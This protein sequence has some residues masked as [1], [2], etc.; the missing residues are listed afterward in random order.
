MKLINVNKRPTIKT[1][2]TNQEKAQNLIKNDT[3]TYPSLFTTVGFEHE[4]G[5]MQNSPLAGVSHLIFAKSDK[6][7]PLTKIP[8]KLETDASNAIE[9][10]SPP[11]IL[12]MHD[13]KAIPIYS[14]V[15]NVDTMIRKLLLG[16]ISTRKGSVNFEKLL[17]NLSSKTGWKFS[18][19]DD[20]EIKSEH[21]SME[22]DLKKLSGFLQA[23]KLKN[24]ELKKFPVDAIEKFKGRDVPDNILS[25]INFAADIDVVNKFISR[26]GYIGPEPRLFYTV[27]EKLKEHLGI[28]DNKR[29]DIFGRLLL[30]RLTS[31]IAV[32]AQ[33]KLSEMQKE[34][35]YPLLDGPEDEIKIDAKDQDE[36]RKLANMIS[37][38]KRIR[39]SWIKDHFTSLAAGMSQ[40]DKTKKKNIKRLETFLEKFEKEEWKKEEVTEKDYEYF[41]KYRRNQLT[42]EQKRLKL[43]PEQWEVTLTE[44]EKE[45]IESK[46][47]E[48]LKELKQKQKRKKPLYENMVSEEYF[49]EFKKIV[50]DSVE[51]LMQ[52]LSG[53]VASTADK[54]ATIGGY[55]HDFELIGSRQDTFIGPGEAN[56]LAR[57]QRLH[58][59]E[60][61][62]GELKQAWK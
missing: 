26:T 41:K 2:L 40:T 35:L 20:L 21:L 3:T 44:E 5:G 34:L 33:Q 48:E 36:F 60:T 43:T 52:E 13:D 42:L 4:F 30:D 46:L 17:A 16:V 31:L 50:V 55:G 18:F 29:D 39:V 9:F 15:Q 58:V 38:V 24:N 19:L 14:M 22:A 56:I 51:K 25:Q 11:F 27:D 23:G 61:D 32:P 28:D 53:S 37:F 57:N 1:Y 54:K 8:F 45:Q 6:E 59:I 12:P 49:E 7:M 47:T 10:V 62:L